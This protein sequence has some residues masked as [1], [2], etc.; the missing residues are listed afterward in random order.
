MSA[1][2]KVRRCNFKC[3]AIEGHA[4]QAHPAQPLEVSGTFFFLTC[5]SFLLVPIMS[6]FHLTRSHT[7]TLGKLGY[8][9]N[10]SKLQM[11]IKKFYEDATCNIEVDGVV[12]MPFPLFEVLD[13]KASDD[14]CQRVEPSEQGGAKIAAELVSRL[15]ARGAF[16]SSGD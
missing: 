8:D 4:S 2:T 3:H 12:C 5:F 1:T 15:V 11:L 14:Y 9:G 13:G 6:P 7:G 16:S 10:P